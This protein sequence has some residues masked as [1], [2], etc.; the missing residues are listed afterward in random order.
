MSPVLD[1]L[2]RKPTL[3]DDRP[4]D[5][6]HLHDS[7]AEGAA[8]STSHPLIVELFDLGQRILRADSLATTCRILAEGMKELTQCDVAAVAKVRRSTCRI[9]AVSQADVFD[10]NA[11]LIQS[12]EETCTNALAQAAQNRLHTKAA[13]ESSERLS[14]RVCLLFA[15]GRGKTSAICVLDGM[16]PTVTD[17]HE[18][19]DLFEETI[20]PIVATKLAALQGLPGRRLISD[21]AARIRSNRRLA[22]TA[23]VAVLA[24]ALFPVPYYV[25]CDCELQPVVRRHVAAPFDGVLQ[26]SLCKPGDVVA[27]G[28][29][30]GRLDAKELTWELASVKA[31]RDRAIKSRDI[32][33]SGAKTAAAQIDR[34]ESLRLDERRKLLEHRLTHLEITSPL[35]G[36]VVSGDLD[37]AEGAPVK[38]G[39]TLYEVAPLNRMVV[40][41]FIPEFDIDR[42][43][44]GQSVS[45]SLDSLFGSA[46]QGTIS[47]IYPRAELHNA[48][49]VFVVEIV[50]ENDE[51]L[52]RPGMKGRV[53]VQT[54]R[55]P[56]FWVATHR[57]FATVSRWIW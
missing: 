32:N 47:R 33:A 49:N 36:V 5:A 43:R 4:R 57:M 29:A 13:A 44:L 28:Q 34:L 12:Y 55:S 24:T 17:R 8:S 22:W 35:A 40:E 6:T 18:V 53:A 50:L 16:P 7:V 23:A 21:L 3:R 45:I 38:I 51:G 14:R 54:D 25:R 39:Q 9:E 56:F 48:D 19:L 2:S 20:G 46:R 11:E 41:A 37:R 27:A 52:L 42:I 30:L 26:Q 10:R 15:D 1:N 31:E